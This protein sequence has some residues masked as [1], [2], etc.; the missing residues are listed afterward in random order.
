MGHTKLP[1]RWRDKRRY[2]AFGREYRLSLV[3]LVEVM[4]N[5]WAKL[6]EEQRIAAIKESSRAGGRQGTG[7]VSPRPAA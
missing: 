6:P 3:D 7:K 5:A 4:A 2:D 1:V